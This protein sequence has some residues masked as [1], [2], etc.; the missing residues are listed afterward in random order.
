MTPNFDHVFARISN[1]KR[2]REAM[3]QIHEDYRVKYPVEQFHEVSRRGAQLFAKATHP[4]PYEMSIKFGEWANGLRAALDS[5]L[6]EIAVFDTGQRPPTRVGDRAFPIFTDEDK[7]NNHKSL[8]GLHP[9]TLERLRVC[10]PFKS[11]TGMTGNALYWLHELAKVDR[12]RHLFDVEMIVLGIDI[13][14]PAELAQYTSSEFITTC[15]EQLAFIYKDKPLKLAEIA[16]HTPI[17]NN[18][19]SGIDVS[20][21][22]GFDVPGWMLNV[23]P[24]YRW[25]FDYRMNSVEEIVEKLTEMF[26]REIKSR[27]ASRGTIS[28]ID[29][30]WVPD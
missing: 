10:Q 9:W 17:P 11:P 5:L 22:V 19:R 13:E 18:L 6:Y 23:H 28:F 14:I 30:Q 20:Y 1:A 24:G 25:R 29:G 16:F 8:K 26:A 12:H 7:F 2:H 21:S 3:Y 15:D 4:Y 27:P